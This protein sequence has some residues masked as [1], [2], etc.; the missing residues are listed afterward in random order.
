EIEIGY[1]P[2]HFYIENSYLMFRDVG[3]L[4]D[5]QLGQF[6]TPMTLENSGSS[7]DMLFME[8][9]TPL[10][11][12]APGVNAGFQVGRPVADERMT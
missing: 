6:Q 11:A 8:A 1:I 7:R 9:A 3:F 10:Q 12:L 5:L 2:D 4:G